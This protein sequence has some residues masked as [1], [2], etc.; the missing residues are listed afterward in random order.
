M[1][2]P[3]AATTLSNGDI[4]TFGKT[5]GKGSYVVPPVTARVELLFGVQ[6]EIGSIGSANTSTRSPVVVPESG[7][8]RSGRISSGRYGLYVPSSLSSPDGSSEDDSS[9]KFDHDSDIEEIT[10]PSSSH[11]RPIRHHF[12]PSLP[13]LPLL[14]GLQAHV[15]GDSHDDAMCFNSFDDLRLPA[16]EIPPERS[17]SHSPMDLSS[18]TPTPI[19]AWP[20]VV[21][22]SPSANSSQESKSSHASESSDGEDSQESEGDAEPSA[23]LAAA[24]VPPQAQAIAENPDL[25]D[26]EAG[27][28]LIHQPSYDGSR[29]PSPPSEF[30]LQGREKEQERQHEEEHEQEIRRRMVEVSAI[31]SRMHVGVVFKPLALQH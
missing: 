4:I 1:L 18:P 15:Y 23:P 7:P 13:V 16:I 26:G 20:L 9:V 21:T 31:I 17:R 5:V 12:G 19:G 11:D 27:T 30:D 22:H 8:T 3:E 29:S 10:P 28:S 2:D 25:R 6:S 14:R 24:V